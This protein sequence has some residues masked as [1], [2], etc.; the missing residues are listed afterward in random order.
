[1]KTYRA[2]A[3]TVSLLFLAGGR[4]GAVGSGGLLNLVPQAQ[5]WIE[6]SIGA[7]ES[8]PYKVYVHPMEGSLVLIRE[9][10]PAALALDK[11]KKHAVELPL[12][13]LKLSKDGTILDVPEHTPFKVLVN[14]PHFNR[15][16]A[17]VRLD[18]NSLLVVSV[19]R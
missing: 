7:R 12:D 2:L 18:N 13:H 14:A 17:S 6:N 8:L 3:L 11:N 4:L 16:F 1:M 5:V 10:V 9:G 15:T 19:A